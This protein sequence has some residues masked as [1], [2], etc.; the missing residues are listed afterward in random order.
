MTPHPRNY[1]ATANIYLTHQI[2][3][4]PKIA[5]TLHRPWSE[6]P[7]PGEGCGACRHSWLFETLRICEYEGSLIDE[8]SVTPKVQKTPPKKG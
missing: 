6:K 7:L 4:L 2:H 5:L 8:T 1:E 3:Y